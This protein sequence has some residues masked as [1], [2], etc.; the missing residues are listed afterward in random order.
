M[1]TIRRFISICDGLGLSALVEAHTAQEVEAAIKAG[2]RVIGVNNRNL[3]NFDV[4]IKTCINLRSLVP[5]SITYV[6]E[7][8]IKSAGDIK[9][10]DAAGVDAVLIGETLM[11]SNDRKGLLRELR[12]VEL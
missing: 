3:Q 6:A 4:D 7:S 8:G 5:E 2:A 12:G 1:E 9:L 10:L 11:R